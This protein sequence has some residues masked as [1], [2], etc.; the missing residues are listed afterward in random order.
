M[1]PIQQHEGRHPGL[2][3]HHPR[4]GHPGPVEGP[5]RPHRRGGRGRAPRGDVRTA[6][7][8][9]LAEEPMHGY[10][11][12]GKLVERGFVRPNR[13]GSGAVY[14]ILRRMDAHGL[15]R[16]EWERT[17]SGRQRRVYEVTEEGVDALK[18]GLETLIKRKA[19]MDD[20]ASFYHE[21]F[22]QKDKV[23]SGSDYA[24]SCN[25]WSR[26]HNSPYGG[27]RTWE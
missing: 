3:H 20:L 27:Y 24:C 10:Q 12:R 16:S 2:R 11:L 25:C 14:T 8:L 6:V 26:N 21:Q 15:L 23:C 1:R 9:L 19:L 22:Q 7:L 18:M 13:L 5:P 4:R 17:Q